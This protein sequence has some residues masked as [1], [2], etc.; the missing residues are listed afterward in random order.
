[1]ERYNIKNINTDQGL[2]SYDMPIN[3]RPGTLRAYY[4][5]DNNLFDTFDS[6]LEVENAIAELG[7]YLAQ[8]AEIVSYYE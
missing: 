6:R 7:P 1:M 4:F 8:E 2:L 3:G 5:W